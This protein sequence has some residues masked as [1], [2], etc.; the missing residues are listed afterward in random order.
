M[1]LFIFTLLLAMWQIPSLLA[2]LTEP[3]WALVV[4]QAALLAGGIFR[5]VQ[6]YMTK[7]QALREREQ[8]R[9]DRA[10]L[11]T[12]TH[13]ELEKVRVSSAE[14]LKTLVGEIQEV[15]SEVIKTK[16]AAVAG[17]RAS[18]AALETANNFNGKLAGLDAAIRQV[19][20]VP[21]QVEVV[22]TPEHPVPVDA[23]GCEEGA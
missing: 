11:A 23:R 8:D 16:S 22:N 9:L 7:R 4:A 10:Q 1:T 14:R 12:L 13:A 20:E 15:K 3:M 17:I 21:R 5:L 6:D 2:F 19:A 18:K